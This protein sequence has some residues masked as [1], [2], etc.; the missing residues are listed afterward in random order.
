MAITAGT[1]RPISQIG[2]NQQIEDHGTTQY[3][4]LLKRVK[5]KDTSSQNY[6]EGEFI[7]LKGLA[8]TAAGDLVV[9]NGDGVTTRSAARVTGPCAVA[10]S[11]CV[12]SEYGWYQIVG[13]AK[14]KSA[15]VAADKQL[16]VTATAGQV[17]DAVVAGDLV[18]NAHSIAADDTGFVKALLNYPTLGDTDNA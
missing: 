3:E 12:A 4:P 15:T 16:Y 6:G 13:I 17:D 10:M 2:L 18:Y 5:C 8:S 11:A 9:F 14:T 7:Y 1:W